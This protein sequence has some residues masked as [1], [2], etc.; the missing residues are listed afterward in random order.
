MANSTEVVQ[1]RSDGL[2]IGDAATDRIGFYGATPVVQPT[3]GTAASAMAALGITPST[4][5]DSGVQHVRVS[6]AA[7]DILGMAAAPVAVVAAPGA[8][9]TLIVTRA[10]FRIVR[11]ATAYANG[12]VVILQYGATA[13]GGGT[14]A[15]DSTIAATVVT[16]AAGTTDSHRN[17][18]VMSDVAAA[19]AE[20]AG[21]YIS[22]GTAA[23]ITGT[24]TATIDVWYVVN[25]A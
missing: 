16:G 22:N 18:A 5:A 8:G 4:F 7:A 3:T 6:L 1:D 13:T 10:A 20:N 19:T 9:K 17:G 11:S 24:G 2:H 12:G 23:F 25:Q 14:Q 15:L 21:L